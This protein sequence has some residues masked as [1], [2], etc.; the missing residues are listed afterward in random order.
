MSRGSNSVSEE[1]VRTWKTGMLPSLL[2]EYSPD[3]ITAAYY[4]REQS[5][6]KKKV[7][8]VARG[9]TRELRHFYGK[10]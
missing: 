1:E 3:I 9:I 6:L 10:M 5:L 2:S 8:M 4:H 7:G